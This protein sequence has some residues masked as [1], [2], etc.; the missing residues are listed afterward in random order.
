MA[1]ITDDAV[2]GLKDLITKLENRVHELEGKLSGSNS[3]ATGSEAPQA[4]RMTIMGP[5]G[6]GV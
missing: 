1:P 3:S 2:S 4:M 6:A 5:P